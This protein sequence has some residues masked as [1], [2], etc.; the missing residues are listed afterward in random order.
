MPPLY[1]VF[2]PPARERNAPTGTQWVGC[3]AGMGFMIFRLKG[4][5][6]PARGNALGGWA[7]VLSPALKGR[8]SRGRGRISFALSGLK[9]IKRPEYPGRCPGLESRRPSGLRNE[10]TT[11]QGQLA[12]NSG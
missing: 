3:S 12:G 7:V 1:S 8:W 5:G 2:P 10:G 11:N 4:G 6:I 9:G